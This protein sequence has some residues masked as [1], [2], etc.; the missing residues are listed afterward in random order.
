MTEIKPQTYV[1]FDGRKVWFVGY[2]NDRKEDDTSSRRDAVI[3][4]ESGAIGVTHEAS[5][6]VWMGPR[7]AKSEALD[8]LNDIF[9]A[10]NEH[11]NTP[12]LH[13]IGLIKVREIKDLAARG[14]GLKP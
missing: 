13:A 14:L 2:K 1:D 12:G 6:A 10:C 5:L 8:R 9:N 4:L 3:V 11:M 7:S